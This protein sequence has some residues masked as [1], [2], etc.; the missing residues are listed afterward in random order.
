MNR[1]LL[2][3]CVVVAS[4][5]AFAAYIALPMVHELG[6]LQGGLSV[7]S[8]LAKRTEIRKDYGSAT[9]APP[10][11]RAVP[12][13]QEAKSERPATAALPSYNEAIWVTVL[14]PARIHTGPSVDTPI[15]NFYPVGTQLHATRYRN[16][17]C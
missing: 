5:V 14:L 8:F 6:R 10:S 17:W 12:E 3:P 1:L 7:A 2:V 16:D 11:F 9:K 13:K 4:Y 15:S